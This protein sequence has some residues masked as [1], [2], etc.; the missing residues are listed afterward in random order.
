MKILLFFCI[1]LFIAPGCRQDPE[2]MTGEITGIVNLYSQSNLKLRDCSGV[3]VDLYQN[4]EL[5][6]STLTDIYGE[7]H[8]MDLQYGKYQVDLQKDNYIKNY[9]P[10]IFN[11]V[12]GNATTVVNCYM[13]EIPDYEVTIDSIKIIEPGYFNVYLKVN[14]DTIIP[15]VNNPYP[16]TTTTIGYSGATAD[17]SPVKYL[18]YAQG[19]MTD[20][21]FMYEH[22]KEAIRVLF[23][24]NT[25]NFRPV[26]SDSVYFRIYPIALGQSNVLDGFDI[27]ALGKPSN[28]VVIRWP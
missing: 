23:T 8:F 24:G 18:G 28:V 21:S 16:F 27:K 15:F 25:G 6:G 13:H 11:H 10:N 9:L 4:S 5:I 7:F 2:T 14:N 1:I 22:K 20:L 17:L 3:K 12:G 26:E 19:Y